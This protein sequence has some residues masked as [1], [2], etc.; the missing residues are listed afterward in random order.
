MPKLSIL[1]STIDDRIFQ[2]ENILSGNIA[3]SEYI[4]VHQ[5]TDAL[6]APIYRDFYNRFS[7]PAYVF[8]QQFAKGTGKSRNCALDIAKG[9]LLYICDDD[10]TLKDNFATSVINAAYKHKDAD[11]YTFMI[12]NTEGL[13]YKKY[14]RNIRRHTLK[15]TARVSNVEMVIRKKFSDSSGVRFDERFGLGT[16][17]NTGEEF[18]FL[19]DALKKNARI[20]FIPEY[21]VVHP[22]ESSGKRYSA[23]L[24][25]AK[26]AMIARVYGWK[27]WFINFAFSIRK[28]HE[29]KNSFSLPLFI[30]YIYSGSFSLAKYD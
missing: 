1:L 6:K 8:I 14:F 2:T 22:Q 12:E 9:E 19:A 7:S 17:F 27:F 16:I 5:I 23:E 28:Y 15:T 29:Y 30:K 25:R 13:S 26:G 21:I 4:I 10:V 18:V 3:D 24:I 11:I 20:L